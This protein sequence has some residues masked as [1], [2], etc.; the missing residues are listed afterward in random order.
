MFGE[1]LLLGLWAVGLM[2]LFIV[3]RLVHAATN[4]LDRH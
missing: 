4:W 1:V 3:M 2:C